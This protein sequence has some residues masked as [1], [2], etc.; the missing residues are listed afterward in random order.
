MFF[1]LRTL[2]IWR[3][4]PHRPWTAIGCTENGQ[5]IGVR[6]HSDLLQGMG[7]SGLGKVTIF[8][9]HIVHSTITHTDIRNFIDLAHRAILSEVP[10]Y[11]CTW[12]AGPGQRPTEKQLS[13]Q[14]WLDQCPPGNTKSGLK[15][16]F[17]SLRF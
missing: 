7:C 1:S 16:L 9:E 10:V 4:L 6:V 2:K 8:L 14:C 3:P 11:V 17:Y 5:P 13:G 12:K 15:I